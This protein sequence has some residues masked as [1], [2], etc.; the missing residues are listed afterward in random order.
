MVMS[1]ENSMALPRLAL[2][3]HG[4]TAWNR[5]GRIQGRSDV[6][7]DAA[8]AAGCPVVAEDRAGVRDVV[9]AQ[10]LAP[11]DR[12]EALAA[13]VDALLQNPGERQAAARQ[14]Q[15]HVQARHLLDHARTTLYEGLCPW[16]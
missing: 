1:Q 6:A 13:R 12:P 14:A 4:P 3:R 15:A 10:R 7:L 2:L 16:L 8:Q 9:P 11:P 5:A